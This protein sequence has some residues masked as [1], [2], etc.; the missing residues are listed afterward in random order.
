[1]LYLLWIWLWLDLD[2]GQGGQNRATKKDHFWPIFDFDH[3]IPAS[4]LFQK[5]YTPSYMTTCFRHVH[6]KF[7]VDS[8]DFAKFIA[9]RVRIIGNFGEFLAQKRFGDVTDWRHNFSDISS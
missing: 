4:K 5:I 7:S 8:T 3:L 2:V 6:V 9:H 1:M